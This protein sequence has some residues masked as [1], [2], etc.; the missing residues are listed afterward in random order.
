MG[1]T[2]C[3]QAMAFYHRDGLISAWQQAMRFYGPGGRIATLPDIVAARIATSVN[4]PAWMSYF[5]TASS[6]FLGRSRAGNVVIAVLHGTGP[7]STLQGARDAYA[8]EFRDKSRN[9]RGGRVSREDFLE[10]LDHG[11]AA[12]VDLE[13]YKRLYR[14]PFN[15]GIT[16]EQAHRD[17]MVRARL[18]SRAGEY[19]ERHATESRMFREDA[20]KAMDPL[21]R[22]L[23]VHATGRILGMDYSNGCSYL[24]AEPEHATAFANLLSI[25]QVSNMGSS[26]DRLSSVWCDVSTHDWTDGTKFLAIRAS[27]PQEEWNGTIHPGFSM[28]TALSSQQGLDILYQPTSM[29]EDTGDGFHA[30]VNVGG[31]FFTQHPKFGI[32]LDSAAPEHPVTFLEEIGGPEP[33]SFSRQPEGYVAFFRYALS[34]VRALA[35]VGANAYILV[36]VDHGSGETQVGRVRFYRAKVD[37][38]RRLPQE[39]D[40][41]K[42]V[43]LVIR[44]ASLTESEA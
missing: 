6:E 14:Y 18:G 10:I 42:D 28:R 9:N 24:H 30:L 7:L 21:S 40:V 15:E 37:R 22:G 4:S 32:S 20:W 11:N 41:S 8:H 33:T 31:R 2:N 36:Q 26:D 27:E 13:D 38:S 16:P 39:A 44:L 29:D 43:G 19:V 12:I 1:D 5:T 34:E 3:I 17:P 25:G 35:P 23:P